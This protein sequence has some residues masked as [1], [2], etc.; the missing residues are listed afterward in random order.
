[1]KTNKIQVLL[2]EFSDNNSYTPEYSTQGNL[3]R[4]FNFGVDNSIKFLKGTYS[5]GITE[6]RAMHI[7]TNGSEVDEQKIFKKTMYLKNIKSVK[8]ELDS[9]QKMA[10]EA[11]KSITGIDYKPMV[12]GKSTNLSSQEILKEAS[13]LSDKI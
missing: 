5:Q 12:K 6:L 13:Q 3:I 9:F 8:T 7:E 4:S 11:Y 2:N 10:R 1:M